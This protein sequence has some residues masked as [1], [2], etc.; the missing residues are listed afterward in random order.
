MSRRFNMEI[1]YDKNMEILLEKH[2]VSPKQYHD[3]ILLSNIES[4]MNDSATEIGGLEAFFPEN[5]VDSFFRVKEIIED[6]V[7]QKELPVAS[8]QQTLHQAL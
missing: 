2:G 3:Y 7:K 6:I 8:L 4:R 1:R 5:T